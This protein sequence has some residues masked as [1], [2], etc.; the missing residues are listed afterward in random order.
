MFVLTFCDAGAF[1]KFEL[2][3]GGSPI[4]RAI[5][6]ASSSTAQSSRDSTRGFGSVLAV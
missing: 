2:P 6:L 5:A 3:A 1:R 4:D